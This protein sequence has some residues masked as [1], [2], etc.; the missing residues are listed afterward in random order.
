MPL[1]LNKV[2]LIGNL[3]N[4]PELRHTTNGNALC[5]LRIATNES[6]K[7]K[8][9]KAQEWTEW[10]NVTVWGEQGV[11]CERY[12]EQGSQ[13]YVEGR[14][15]TRKYEKDGQT[16]YA[17]DIEGVRVLFLGG[18]GS[19]STPTG[20]DQMPDYPEEDMPI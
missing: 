20:L 3:G 11:N 17:T 2:Q 13:V 6:W 18:R 12:L 1:G 15:K 16:R 8:S 4:P 19:D 10:H 7:D 9:G 5:K 14:L